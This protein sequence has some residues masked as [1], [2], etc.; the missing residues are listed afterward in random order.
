MYKH[1]SKIKASQSK[2]CS[3]KKTMST[4]I[5]EIYFGIP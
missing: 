3:Y 1:T 5:P 4:S 2:G